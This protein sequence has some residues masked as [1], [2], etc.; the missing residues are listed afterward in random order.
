MSERITTDLVE[1]HAKLDEPAIRQSVNEK[2]P[3]LRPWSLC[4]CVGLRICGS[5][6]LTVVVVV[7]YVLV[8]RE[9]TVVQT[10]AAGGAL[11]LD[12]A[13]H[14]SNLSEAFREGTSC[15][16]GWWYLLRRGDVARPAGELGVD[17]VEVRVGDDRVPERRAADA[18]VDAT[19]RLDSRALGF[20]QRD[21]VDVVRVQARRPEGVARILHRGGEAV[22]RDADRSVGLEVDRDR[23]E[24]VDAGVELRNLRRREVLP[25]HQEAAQVL[26][27]QRKVC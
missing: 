10:A 13:E 1:E 11:L 21:A 3:P 18:H 27:A 23:L 16:E 7:K 20:R 19:H 24:L 12:E 22:R 17:A 14:S 2:S 15:G 4:L 9:A 6:Q 8:L 25:E 5:L 26:Y